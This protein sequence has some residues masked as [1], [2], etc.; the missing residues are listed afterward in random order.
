[1]GRGSAASRRAAGLAVALVLAAVMARLLTLALPTD[2]WAAE[3]ALGVGGAVYAVALGRVSRHPW[4]GGDLAVIVRGL[5]GS[6]IAALMVALA[7]GHLLDGLD[8]LTVLLFTAVHLSAPVRARARALLA[9]TI[10][11]DA[12]FASV[13]LVWLKSDVPTLLFA[14]A[15][16][17]ALQLVVLAHSK[18]AGA[19][20]ASDKL[21]NSAHAVTAERVGTAIDVLGVARAVL[22][23][24]RESYPLTTHAAVLLYDTVAD[25]LRP[26]PLYLG[27]DGVG[28]L[29]SD[30]LDFTMAPGEG[31]AGRIF[32][33]SRP[34]LWLTAYDVHMAQS[35]LGEQVREQTANLRRGV[36]LC[37]IGAPLIIDDEVIG[38]YVLTSH[39]QEL[40]WGEEDITV[41]SALAAEAARAIE[42]ARRY[43]RELDQAHLDS[44]TGL[45]NHRQLT[46]TL[47]QEVARARRRTTPLGVVFCDLDRFKAVNDTYGHAAGD[48]VL[49]ILAQVF[50]AS[51]RRED[52]AARYGGDEFVCVLPGADHVEALAVGLR[53]STSFE[54]RVRDDAELTKAGVTISCGVAIFPDDA[55][56]VGG[57]LQHADAAMR[58]VKA[59]HRAGVA[60]VRRSG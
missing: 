7:A 18:A 6:V 41:V 32:S 56:D 3:L 19:S 53:I 49:T 55:D 26:L 30:N 46:R 31:L 39:R 54:L 8:V 5:I 16:M 21:R 58:R 4:A 23:T 17:T 36:P 51:L 11:V 2:Q 47:D 22:E 29:D 24:S 1:V 57:L 59:D 50:H 9:A 20:A 25:R 15:L 42:R 34:M 40:V 45:A 37:A 27:P 10:L 44:I 60:E 35:N 14:L 48:R 33:A 28:S 43:E 38:V 12:A 52:S 13:W